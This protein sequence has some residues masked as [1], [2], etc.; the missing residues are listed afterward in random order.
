MPVLV[1]LAIVLLNL[2]F[3]K[4]API[5]LTLLAPAIVVFLIVSAKHKAPDR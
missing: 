4:T 1:V 2:F 5:T 3:L